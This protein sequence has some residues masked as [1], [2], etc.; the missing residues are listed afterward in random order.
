MTTFIWNKITEDYRLE[1]GDRYV[2]WTIYELKHASLI[3]R[4]KVTSDKIQKL[5]HEHTHKLV[6]IHFK[7]QCS[8]VTVVIQS[9]HITRRPRKYE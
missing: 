6:N 7:L 8:L 9:D 4:K 1:T 2:H 5:N 3:G